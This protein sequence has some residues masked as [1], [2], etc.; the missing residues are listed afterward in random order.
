M[1]FI[2]QVLVLSQ[3]EMSFKISTLNTAL[4]INRNYSLGNLP[5]DIN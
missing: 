5:A 3:T 1:L 2:F 4:V